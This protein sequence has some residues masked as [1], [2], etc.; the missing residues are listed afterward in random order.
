MA[1]GAPTTIGNTV[2]ASFF[3]PPDIGN[4]K[5]GDLRISSGV[6]APAAACRRGRS[7]RI[8]S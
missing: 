6:A 4:L 7:R 2:C 1:E 8:M 5:E 3:L